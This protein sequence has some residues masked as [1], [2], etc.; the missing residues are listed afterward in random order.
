[1]ILAG[2]AV[3]PLG[4]IAGTIGRS[5]QAF[6]SLAVLNEIMS[7]PGEDEGEQRHINRTI[8]KGSV[9]FDKI[10]NFHSVYGFLSGLLAHPACKSN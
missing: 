4:Q 7:V 1:M 10:E 3:G 8:S 6:H 5:Q 2:R 9:E